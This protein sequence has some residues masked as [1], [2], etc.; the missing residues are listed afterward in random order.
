MIEYITLCGEILIVSKFE[1]Q[2]FYEWIVYL[3]YTFHIFSQKDAFM[4][5]ISSLLG[6]VKMGN[7]SPCEV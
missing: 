2:T 7:D 6:V 4:N 3:G 5:F 1:A